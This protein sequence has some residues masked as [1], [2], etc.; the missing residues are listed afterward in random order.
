VLGMVAIFTYNFD[1]AKKNFEQAGVQL[2]TLSDYNVMIKEA[3]K[4]K[5][6]TEEEAESL[7]QW[8]KDPAGWLP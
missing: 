6:V 3:L 1:L 5:Y 7:R 8:R 4:L 2:I